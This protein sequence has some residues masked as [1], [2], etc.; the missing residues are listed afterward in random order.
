MAPSGKT[1]PAVAI[2]IVV[3]LEALSS[4]WFLFGGPAL[5]FA[6][7]TMHLNGDAQKKAPRIDY[8]TAF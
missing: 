6:P 7:M 1:S 3:P 2:G 4:S 8:I 5:V